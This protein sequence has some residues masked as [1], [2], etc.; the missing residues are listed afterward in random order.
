[1]CGTAYTATDADFSNLHTFR[2]YIMKVV[3]S[4]HVAVQLLSR[5]AVPVS[6]LP[7]CRSFRKFPIVSCR[8][9]RLSV[10]IPSARY[11]YSNIRKIITPARSKNSMYIISLVQVLF[12]AGNQYIYLIIDGALSDTIKNEECL[13]TRGKRSKEIRFI[14][15]CRYLDGVW[16][17]QCSPFFCY[18]YNFFCSNHHLIHA[19]NQRELRNRV[20]T[21]IKRQG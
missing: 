7:W 4:K 21:K 16:N 10:F 15:G 3:L 18:F 19:T 14:I 13:V 11:K 9:S 5:I 8:V 6:A 20:K 1:M 17:D 12:C 2:C